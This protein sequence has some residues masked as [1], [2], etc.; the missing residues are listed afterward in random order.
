MIL[1]LPVYTSVLTHSLWATWEVMVDCASLDAKLKYPIFI[2]KFCH[3]TN[4]YL[5]NFT[6]QMVFGIYI[7]NTIPIKKNVI[8]IFSLLFLILLAAQ[9]KWFIAC[10]PW[11]LDVAVPKLTGFKHLSIDLCSSCGT[12]LSRLCQQI[13]YSYGTSSS[14]F[15]CCSL[16]NS[17]KILFAGNI[18]DGMNP[19]GSNIDDTMDRIHLLVVGLFFKA[20]E[21]PKLSDDIVHCTPSVCSLGKLSQSRSMAW[22]PVARSASGMDFR[23]LWLLLVNFATWNPPI[24]HAWRNSFT[25]LMA[26]SSWSTDFRLSSA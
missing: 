2:C 11:W 1:C 7:L 9:H 19:S 16:Y 8:L 13:K 5:A 4:H 25:N 14:Q 3:F 6:V 26:F 24:L 10:W 23:T 21:K 18:N 22:I 15:K 12:P 17:C 20:I